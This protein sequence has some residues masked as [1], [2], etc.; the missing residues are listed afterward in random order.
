M[1]EGAVSNARGKVSA[2]RHQHNSS[3]VNHEHQHL[4]REHTHQRHTHAHIAAPDTHTLVAHTTNPHSTSRDGGV[5]ESERERELNTRDVLI[6]R[7]VYITHQSLIIASR[8]LHS[9]AA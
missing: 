7:R 4:Q 5:T 9:T 6:V 1:D 2:H 3:H 8:P